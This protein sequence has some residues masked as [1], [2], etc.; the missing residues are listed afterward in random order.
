MKK[1]KNILI[2]ALKFL[3]I[4]ES[5]EAKLRNTLEKK[6]YTEQEISEVIDYLKKRN[7]LNDERFARIVIEKNLRRKKGL[8]YIRYLLSSS[9]I[10]ETTIS[11]ILAKM[12]PESLEYKIAKE[13]FSSLK[14]P[15]QKALY[16]LSSRGFTENT[17]EKIKEEQCEK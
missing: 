14:K 7:F 13:L 12:Y 15:L 17:I 2:D 5:S 6:G 10:S 8:N 3:K 9:G 1:N 11:Q 16:T 4:K